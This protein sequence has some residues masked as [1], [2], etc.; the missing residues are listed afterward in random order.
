MVVYREMSYSE[1]DNRMWHMVLGFLC[2]FFNEIQF[3]KS[4]NPTPMTNLWLVSN[5][6]LPAHRASTQKSKNKGFIVL[7]LNM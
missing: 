6:T 7:L 4:I 2:V 3:N 5:P 1:K